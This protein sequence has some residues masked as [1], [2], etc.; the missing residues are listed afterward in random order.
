MKRRSKRDT[1]YQCLSIDLE[2][3]FRYSAHFIYKCVCHF[4]RPETQKETIK[5]QMSSS[6][7][8]DDNLLL[9]RNSLW[10]W[11]FLNGKI[12]HGFKPFSS[13]LLEC[14]K[15]SNWKSAIIWIIPCPEFISNQENSMDLVRTSK[16]F[17]I[18]KYYPLLWHLHVVYNVILLKDHQIEFN[19]WKNKSV[20]FCRSKCISVTFK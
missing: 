5:K 16:T 7:W 1:L 13:K 19:R 2:F 18:D 8:I 17:T 6:I 10:F 14:G 3:V 15:I 4:Y 11:F 20:F 12:F 9:I